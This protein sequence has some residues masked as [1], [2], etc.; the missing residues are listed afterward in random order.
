MIENLNHQTRE[1][2]TYFIL[3]AAML[4]V[5]IIGQI[6]QILYVIFI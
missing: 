1:R 5:G 6:A 3:A 4:M 2:Q